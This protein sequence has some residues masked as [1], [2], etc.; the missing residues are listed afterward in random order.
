M[1]HQVI[2]PPQKI[3]K[4]LGGGDKEEVFKP[5]PPPR[6][7]WKEGG[8]RPDAAGGVAINKKNAPPKMGFW[9]GVKSCACF[10]PPNT[11]SGAVFN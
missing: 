9:G 8:P 10:P 7:G 2:L 3:G 1:Q 5:P 11:S 6:G 4:V